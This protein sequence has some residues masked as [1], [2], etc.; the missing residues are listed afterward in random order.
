MHQSNRI[1]AHSG[2]SDCED[3]TV[4][5]L[6]GRRHHFGDIVMVEG[7]EVL[8]DGTAGGGADPGH[9]HRTADGGQQVQDEA[10][11]TTYHYHTAIRKMCLTFKLWSWR[12]WISKFKRRKSH[13]Q[14]LTS[15]RDFLRWVENGFRSKGVRVDVLILSPRLSEPKVVERQIL[16]GVLAI[17]RLT[18]LNQQTGKIPLKMFKRIPGAA[19]VAYDGTFYQ[20]NTCGSA[21]TES[22]R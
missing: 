13:I 2:T 16:E 1:V 21:Q 7:L 22:R 5:G 18:R 10:S 20:T 15:G 17:C 8:I 9:G 12:L 14:M 4:T 3:A 11:R 19:E 6:C